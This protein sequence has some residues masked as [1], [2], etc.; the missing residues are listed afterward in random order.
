MFEWSDEHRMMIEAVRQ[1]VD[2]EIVPHLTEL[3]H[4]DL[5]PYD[6]LRKM[7]S[8]FGIDAAARDSC[9][10]PLRSGGGGRPALAATEP[11]AATAARIRP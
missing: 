4:G 10:A 7:F 1:F 3:E 8:T 2:K 11:L 9:R 5:P 6:L